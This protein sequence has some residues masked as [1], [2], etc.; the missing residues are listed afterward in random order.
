MRRAWARNM[1]ATAVDSSAERELTR[2]EFTVFG[3][4]S[5]LVGEVYESVAD[6]R[7]PCSLTA[8]R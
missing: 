2:L 5:K 7:R 6:P 4:I 8:P 1:G 3:F